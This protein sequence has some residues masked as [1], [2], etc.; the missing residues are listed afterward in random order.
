MIN[1][2]LADHLVSLFNCGLTLIL[3]SVMVDLTDNFSFM[4]IWLFTA[5][6]RV[7]CF[8][9]FRLMHY[10]LLVQHDHHDFEFLGLRRKSIFVNLLI[11]LRYD[12]LTVHCCHPMVDLLIS[13]VFCQ[14]VSSNG[15]QLMKYRTMLY[16]IFKSMRS[17][18]RIE[19]CRIDA[20]HTYG[21]VK[22][23]HIFH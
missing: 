22:I 18:C 4:F 7:A 6:L 19:M 21:R 14:P 3:W 23:L 11:F 17:N 9:V 2:F 8:L 15:R 12:N 16:L 5:C 13:W 10:L 20:L 1:H